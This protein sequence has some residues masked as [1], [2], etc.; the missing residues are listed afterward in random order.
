MGQKAEGR[1]LGGK[2]TEG[3]GLTVLKARR[4]GACWTKTQEE[5]SMLGINPEGRELSKRKARRNGA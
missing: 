3:W 1:G 5:E 4:K 2:T